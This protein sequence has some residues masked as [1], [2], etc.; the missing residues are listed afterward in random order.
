MTNAVWKLTDDYCQTHIRGVNPVHEK[1]A[2]FLH[3]KAGSTYS[4]YS[5]M[6]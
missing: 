5:T 2:Q 3:V 4:D 6:L 1:N